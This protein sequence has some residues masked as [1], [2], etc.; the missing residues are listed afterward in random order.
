MTINALSFIADMMKDAGIRYE[1]ARFNEKPTYPYFVGE[2]TE[3][4]PVNEDG[5]QETNFTITGYGRKSWLELEKEKQK[6]MDIFDPIMGK[7]K[8]SD[9]GT[10]TIVFYT[11]AYIIPSADAELKRIQINLIVKEWRV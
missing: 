9:D 2:Y 5:F 1:F 4:V 6:I 3:N 10:V 7:R 8:V 11:S